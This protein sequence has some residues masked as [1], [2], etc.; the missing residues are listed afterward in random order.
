MLFTQPLFPSFI[1]MS[2]K[3]CWHPIKYFLPIFI[4]LS[5]CYVDEKPDSNNEKESKVIAAPAAVETFQI[6][7]PKPVIDFTDK[8][9]PFLTAGNNPLSSKPDPRCTWEYAEVSLFGDEKQRLK[10]R[11]RACYVTYTF[12]SHNGV[13]RYTE[14]RQ[15]MY[16]NLPQAGLTSDLLK[17][18]PLDGSGRAQLLKG[19]NATT[20]QEK[21]CQFEQHRNYRRKSKV[22]GPFI[23]TVNNVAYRSIPKAEKVDIKGMDNKQARNAYKYAQIEHDK[24]YAEQLRKNA[25]CHGYPVAKY[26]IE[27]E[28]IVLQVPIYVAHEILGLNSIIYTNNRKN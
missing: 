18:M 23:W 25:L 12:S 6:L 15:T 28:G 4:F 21:F 24:K 7:S 8:F 17:V 14:Q 22:P 16:E 2:E 1:G 13:I 9:A 26:S 19:I 10:F 27:Y 20:E 3:L 11:Y 5:G